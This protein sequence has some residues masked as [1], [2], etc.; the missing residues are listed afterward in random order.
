MRART[1]RLM[2]AVIAGVLIYAFATLGGCAVEAGAPEA[3]AGAAGGRPDVSVSEDQFIAPGDVAVQ[4][5]ALT[6]TFFFINSEDGAQINR[7]VPGSWDGLRCWLM[8]K[9]AGSTSLC[10]SNDYTCTFNTPTP[11]NT[12]CVGRT[13]ALGSFTTLCGPPG[14]DIYQ[15]GDGSFPK[16]R[17]AYGT[18]SQYVFN[19]GAAINY[20]YAQ[21]KLVPGARL[22]LS[23]TP[24]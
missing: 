18:N 6:K 14:C 11:G 2:D 8:Q 15:V 1:L 17:F 19:S 7:A 16:G 23:T 20:P 3:S 9:C 21:C 13:S 5:Q 22:Q 24:L 10:R 12:K 4:S